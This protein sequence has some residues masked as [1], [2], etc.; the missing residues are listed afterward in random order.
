LFKLFS[1]TYQ[2]KYNAWNGKEMFYLFEKL[3]RKR[4]LAAV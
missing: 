3:Q 1:A 4:W 2:Y